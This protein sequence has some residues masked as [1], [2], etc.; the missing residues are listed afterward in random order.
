M[1]KW[2]EKWPMFNGGHP[3][4]M[5]GKPKCFYKAPP[6]KVLETSWNACFG[7]EQTL[8]LKKK[9]LQICAEKMDQNR[10]FKSSLKRGTWGE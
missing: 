7:L 4:S 9:A 8:L 6:G 2:A 10:K 5:G 1:Y 3:G